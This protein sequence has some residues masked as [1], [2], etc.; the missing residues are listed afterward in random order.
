MST[1]EPEKTEPLKEESGLSEPSEVAERSNLPEQKNSRFSTLDDDLSFLNSLPQ[2]EKP[3]STPSSIDA[4]LA[5]LSKLYKNEPR[6]SEPEQTPPLPVEKPQPVDTP[7]LT[8]EPDQKENF[9]PAPPSTAPAPT[10]E[11]NQTPIVMVAQQPQ[12]TG[13]PRTQNPSGQK[14]RPKKT[15]SQI[16]REAKNRLEKEK[17]DAKKR[18]KLNRHQ[19]AEK[20]RALPNAK[21]K[22]PGKKGFF[23]KFFKIYGRT[24][25]K[26]F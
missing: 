10:R 1:I 18:E 12:R 11:K 16:Q 20:G 24:F 13:P 9:R 6:P 19:A 8:P 2:I 22:P 21:A 15:Q 14:Q 23:G 25:G 17:A 7:P 4:H 26:W 5:L 3:K